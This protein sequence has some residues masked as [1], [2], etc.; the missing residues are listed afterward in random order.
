MEHPSRAAVKRLNMSAF[1]VIRPGLLLALAFA[2]AACSRSEPAADAGGA[3]PADPGGES[4]AVAEPEPGEEAEERPTR[5]ERIYYDLT[6]YEWY[7]QGRPLVV[8]GRNYMPSDVPITL[9]DTPL[10]KAGEYEGVDYYVVEDA[11]PP[12]AVVYVPVFEDY[13][14]PFAPVGG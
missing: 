11:E 3:G 2:L 1:D 4:V 5:P 7:R 10:E 13:W 14:L 8:D 12:Y 9:P 6:A